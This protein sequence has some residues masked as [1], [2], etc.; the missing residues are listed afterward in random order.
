M[1]GQEGQ[2]TR[3]TV[4]N[5]KTGRRKL[6][7]LA[8]LADVQPSPARVADTLIILLH[9]SSLATCTLDTDFALLP[10]LKLGEG[11]GG[12]R[13]RRLGYRY[14]IERMPPGHELGLLLVNT[15]RKCGLDIADGRA[16]AQ[17]EYT[18]TNPRGPLCARSD[19]G[20]VP[21]LAP[22]AGQAHQARAG[23]GRAD[24]TA[25][26]VH[27]SARDAGR[28]RKAYDSVFIAAARH[29][30]GGPIASAGLRTVTA[31][32]KATTGELKDHVREQAQGLL[33][34]VGEGA[35][36]PPPPSV[37]VSRSVLSSPR[38]GSQSMQLH[39]P[40]RGPQRELTTGLRKLTPAHLLEASA[41]AAALYELSGSVDADPLLSHLRNLLV[42][43]A[44]GK[45]TR[46]PSKAEPKGPDANTHVF[47]LRCL[48]LLPSA[49]WQ[50]G[51]RDEHMSAIMSGTES[52]DPTVRRACRGNDVAGRTD[53]AARASEVIEIRSEGLPDQERAKALVSGVTRISQALEGIWV[54]GVRLLG[55]LMRVGSAEFCRA[56]VQAAAQGLQKE[57]EQTLVVALATV[58]CE[59]PCPGDAPAVVRAL[60]RCL[61]DLEPSVQEI[62]MLALGAQ[63]AL[64]PERERGSLVDDSL[65]A[66]DSLKAKS[67]K[68]I[69]KEAYAEATKS[70]PASPA[71]S[72][73]TLGPRKKPKSGLRYSYAQPKRTPTPKSPM[74]PMS[75]RSPGSASSGT[76]GKGKSK[77]RGRSK[78]LK[79]PKSPLERAAE[80]A[81]FKAMGRSM[82]AEDE[83]AL[84][85]LRLGGR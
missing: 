21:P 66:L 35:S 70:A 1:N 59:F 12:M 53:A 48:S 84:D 78:V 3:Q 49:V 36:L 77:D 64:I 31:I 55:G 6:R 69:A 76:E 72:D 27:C 47:V 80:L 11:G 14:L 81:D 20:R 63:L 39:S 57:T 42:P 73:S 44:K 8:S 45:S 4:L 56:V 58:A 28:R 43:R 71:M 32:V 65:R 15:V 29:A 7:T 41:L 38:S 52:L 26:S 16:N 83:L 17:P 9:C 85:E 10:A 51:L 61:P 75:P 74:S 22:A 30:D 62:G 46:S 34:Q 50:P 68:H 67:V 37:S 13:E 23:P 40:Q 2:E 19:G 54:D 25:A 60:M 5:W 79:S 24:W 18:T 82:L 33:E